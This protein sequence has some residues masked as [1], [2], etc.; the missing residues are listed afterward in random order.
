LAYIEVPPLT[1]PYPERM[2]G[3]TA[4]VRVP[5]TTPQKGGLDGGRGASSLGSLSIKDTPTITPSEMAWKSYR[6]CPNIIKG[7]YG[8]LLTDFC[9]YM[10]MCDNSGF[11]AEGI[12]VGSACKSYHKSQPR[13]DITTGKREYQKPQ[14]SQNDWG[15]RKV[16]GPLL[17]R[18]HPKRRTGWIA[19]M[20]TVSNWYEANRIEGC[21][22]ITLTGYQENSGLSFYDTWDAIAESRV[23]LLK[24]LRKYLGKISYFW[25]VEPH[26]QNET[27]YPHFHLAVFKD[28]DNHIR[29]SSEHVGWLRVES[30]KDT[31]IWELADGEGME[32]KLR[33]LYSEEWKTGSHTYGLDFTPM[34]GDKSIKD[35]KNYL[36]KYIAKGYIG[37]EIWSPGEL[38]FNA[39]LYGATH[40][41][42]PPKDGEMPDIK[43][44]YTKKYRLIGMS[45][46]LSALIK[47]FEEDKEDIVWLHVDETEPTD[48]KNEDGEYVKVERVK[49]LFDR[50]LIPDWLDTWREIAT[51][52]SWESR[53]YDE[54]AARR[55]RK[56]QQDGYL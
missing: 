37:D 32:D 14:P 12:A 3:Y 34:K 36:M 35:L 23:K 15:K 27:G 41:A 4:T 46:D 6:A 19:K 54:K 38:I 9:R 42:R 33:R 44:N 1:P 52:Q 16:S 31:E 28:V 11:S 43:G 30:R 25:V 22:L 7:K 10:E 56:Q 29:D 50:L 5:A 2:G 18:W 45:R 49:T 53:I 47:P 21:T 24:I 51:T 8:K 13:M 26:T 39:H 40:G 48:Q 20:H 55:A 17:N